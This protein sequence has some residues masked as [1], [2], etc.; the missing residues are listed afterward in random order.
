M[1]TMPLKNFCYGNILS[2]TSVIIIILYTLFSKRQLPTSVQIILYCQT[3]ICLNS[4]ST[5]APMSCQKFLWQTQRFAFPVILRPESGRP[6]VRPSVRPGIDGF[7]LTQE[8]PQHR[9]MWLKSLKSGKIQLS[10]G[11]NQTKKFNEFK[12]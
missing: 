3:F 4:C 5:C 7:P 2:E 6:L 10:T 11:E 8:N 12:F 9:I 1:Q